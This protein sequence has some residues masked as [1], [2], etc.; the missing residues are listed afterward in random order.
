MSAPLQ[1]ECARLVSRAAARPVSADVA[2]SACPSACRMRPSSSRTNAN[3]IRASAASRGAARVAVRI[4]ERSRVSAAGRSP[5]LRRARP[6]ARRAVA[7]AVWDTLSRNPGQ[8][9]VCCGEGVRGLCSTRSRARCASSSSAWWSP[10]VANVPPSADFVHEMSYQASQPAPLVRIQ[11]VG[12]KEEPAMSGEQR[13][14]T[15][16]GRQQ[17]LKRRSRSPRL[18][19]VVDEV[20][21]ASTPMPG[22]GRTTFPSARRAAAASRRSSASPIT[23]RGQIDVT[24]DPRQCRRSRPGQPGRGC[25]G[26]PVPAELDVR[27][28]RIRNPT[29]PT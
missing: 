21:P 4:P 22:V 27:R 11:D 20:S 15:E 3:D 26:A 10:T 7:T 1:D 9:R 17:V 24:Q 6:A 28:S 23:P 16:S 25:R 12:R 8:H 19:E 14:T 18:D 29:Q 2:R 5:R 13:T